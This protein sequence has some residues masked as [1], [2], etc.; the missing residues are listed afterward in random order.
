MYVIVM[1]LRGFPH[2]QGGVETHAEQLY[3]ELVKM[4]CRL[5]VIVRS[6]YIPKEMVSWN[7]IVFR[8]IWSPK[9]RGIE[10]IMHSLLCVI[11]ASIKRPD[12]LHIHA[13]GPA[14]VTPL[15][16]LFGLTVVVTH[17]GHD[18]RREKWGRLA[19][20]VLI[21]GEEFGMR[22]SNKRIVISNEI[23]STVFEKYGCDSIVIPNGVTINPVPN[24]LHSIKELHLVSRKYILMVSR[25]VPEKRHLDLIDAFSSADL[26][27][28]KL[29]LVGDVDPSDK[30]TNKVILESNKA[31]NVIIAG[32]R[33]GIELQELYANAGIYV[34]PSSHE[35]LPIVLLE[36]LSYGI[37]VLASDIQA[38]L[39]VGLSPEYYF[40]LGDRIAL[41]DLLK[42]HSD[43]QANNSDRAKL[44][45]LIS[46]RYNW[47]KI[48]IQTL[49]VY[50]SASNS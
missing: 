16:R 33:S 29:V 22:F 44:K 30:Y 10:A 26:R 9:L 43:H 12:I 20:W 2:V 5:E 8:K 21:K 40:P 31:K 37:P 34:L 27:G 3:Q 49:S 6:S 46:D 41:S 13:I 4:N 28:W 45:S 17:H 36:A 14:I 24:T 18:Y 25:Y 1:G 32:Y 15:A 7:G 42:Y 19:R 11:Y 23:R 38:N 48:A 39:E 50:Q 47:E 35:G